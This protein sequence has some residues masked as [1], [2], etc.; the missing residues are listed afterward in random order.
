MMVALAPWYVVTAGAPQSL[1]SGWIVDGFSQSTGISLLFT[2]G[3]GGDL[4]G[5]DPAPTPSSFS[6]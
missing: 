2:A 1:N 5:R 3:G 6:R 4:L